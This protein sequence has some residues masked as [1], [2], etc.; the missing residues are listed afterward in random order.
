MVRDMTL[1]MLKRLGHEVVAAADGV[2]AMEVFRKH[3]D[4]I[5]CVLLDL[6]MPRRDGWKTLAA[7]LALRPGL[8]V[9]LT[10]GYDE[11]QA[12]QGE[13]AEQPQVFLH[14]PFQMAELRSALHAAMNLNNVGETG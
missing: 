14:K 13:H 4:R 6:T 2:E 3:L 10:S 5:H 8:P 7:L 1:V 11:A 9:V 12:M